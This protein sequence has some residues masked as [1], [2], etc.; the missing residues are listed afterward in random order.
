[1]FLYLVM[2]PCNLLQLQMIPLKI[3]K[4]ISNSFICT[5]YL[6]ST[7]LLLQPTKGG[8]VFCVL[9]W[10]LRVCECVCAC[11]YSAFGGPIAAAN[12]PHPTESSC[13]CCCCEN[14]CHFPLRAISGAKSFGLSPSHSICPA[15]HPAE[16]K[17]ENIATNSPRMQF[18][19]KHNGNRI[20]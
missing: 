6:A 5:G 9:L 2:I 18:I 12:L 16:K 19:S 13:C 7:Y 3:A 14:C 10:Y 15:P 4:K 1:M 20:Y 11:V 17:A 8:H